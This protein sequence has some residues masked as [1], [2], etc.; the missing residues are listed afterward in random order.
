MSDQSST[1][2]IRSMS[3]WHDAVFGKD[4]N[5]HKNETRDYSATNIAATLARQSL[6]RLTQR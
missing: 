1:K 2:E 3:E 6:E 5:P 4:S